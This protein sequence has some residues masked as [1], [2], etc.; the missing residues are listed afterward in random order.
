MEPVTAGDTITGATSQ[1]AYNANARQSGHSGLDMT[2]GEYRENPERRRM[3]QDLDQR[4]PQ[5]VKDNDNEP[6]LR[7]RTDVPAEHG[8]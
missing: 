2:S 5:A 3:G 4:G 1:D 7:R 8:D 6:G